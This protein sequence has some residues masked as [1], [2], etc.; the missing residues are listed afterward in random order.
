MRN[1]I[2]L[3]KLWKKL[4]NWNERFKALSRLYLGLLLLLGFSQGIISVIV[5]LLS[6][7]KPAGSR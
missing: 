3:E 1:Y 7:E 6:P 2:R 4:K 5:L